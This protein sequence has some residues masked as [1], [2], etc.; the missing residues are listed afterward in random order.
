MTAPD[1]SGTDDAGDRDSRGT[2]REDALRPRP[3]THGDVVVRPFAYVHDGP[4]LVRVP[5]RDAWLGNVHAADPSQHDESFAHVLSLTRDVQPATTRHR[6]FADDLDHDPV[7]FRTAVD[8]AR[9]LL[10]ADGDVLVHC[11]AGVSRSAA[12]LATALAADEDHSFRDALGVVQRARPVA[13]PNPALVES[14]V[15]YLA[16]TDAHP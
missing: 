7:A 12:V 9:R 10:A 8:D 2:W 11:K 14:A 15:A 13:T 3:W 4:V 5:G 16:A 6:P 1:D